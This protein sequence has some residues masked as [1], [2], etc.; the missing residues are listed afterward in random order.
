MSDNTGSHDRREK[1]RKNLTTPLRAKFTLDI[2]GDISDISPEGMTIMFH[3][4]EISRLHVNRTIP[5][6]VE[7][8]GCLISIDAHVQHITEESGQIRIGIKYDRDQIAVFRK[9]NSAN[10]KNCAG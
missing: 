4:L 8:N 6:H 10:K 7:M 3:P 5:M 9:I 1:E 2:D